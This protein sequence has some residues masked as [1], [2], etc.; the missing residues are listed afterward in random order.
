MA[1]TRTGICI[2]GVDFMVVLRQEKSINEPSTNAPLPRG[3]AA[4]ST[5]L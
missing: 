1:P 2:H 5:T 3:I 4:S